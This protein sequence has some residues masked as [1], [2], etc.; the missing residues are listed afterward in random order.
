MNKI[1]IP[2]ED[3][4]HLL[5]LG[6]TLNKM[7]FKWKAVGPLRKP[8]GVTIWYDEPID[9]YFIGATAV[10]DANGIFKSPLTR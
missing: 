6:Q 4:D 9:L 1:K 5:Q 10:A 7:C 3:Y 8:S 2:V